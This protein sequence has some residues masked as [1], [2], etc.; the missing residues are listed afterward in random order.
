MDSIKPYYSVGKK[1]ESY[2]LES[3]A[4]G[5]G[6][7]IIMYCRKCKYVTDTTQIGIR[8]FDLKHTDNGHGVGMW[9]SN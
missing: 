1:E 6:N 2:K 9:R 5:Y 3:K 7:K 4:I 8:T